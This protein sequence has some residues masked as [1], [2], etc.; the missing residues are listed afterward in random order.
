[1]SV[2]RFSKFISN[3]FLPR[4]PVA[5]LGRW[6]STTPQYKNNVLWFHDMCNYDNC[7]LDMFSLTKIVSDSGPSAPPPS[8][9]PSPPSPPPSPPPPPPLMPDDA[10]LEIPKPPPKK[11]FYP[12]EQYL[13]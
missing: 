8:P 4:P 12:E 6:G 2:A 11:E 3:M 1:M 5:G 13:Y 9:P 7:Y 10:A